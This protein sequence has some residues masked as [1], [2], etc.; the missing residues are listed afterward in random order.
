MWRMF[1]TAKV[2]ECRKV[3]MMG[4]SDVMNDTAEASSSPT[5]CM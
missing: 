4:C 5:Y 2:Q 3:R 1:E